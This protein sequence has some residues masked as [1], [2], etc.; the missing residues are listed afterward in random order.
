MLM[1]G[2]YAVR[3]TSLEAP[4]LLNA[5]VSLPTTSPFNCQLVR[6]K[7]APIPYRPVPLK[8]VSANQGQI[9]QHSTDAS[10]G[11][12]NERMNK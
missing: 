7:E 10:N 11:T 12:V 1:F 6:L 9:L 5:L 2:P 8:Q 3:P 4:K